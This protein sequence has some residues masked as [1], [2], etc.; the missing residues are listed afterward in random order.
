VPSNDPIQRFEDILENI[1]LIEEFTSGMSPNTFLEDLKTR[2]AT[3]RCM[4]RISEAARK[5]GNWLRNCVQLF[6]GPACAR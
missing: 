5:L 2:N 3:E 4:E 1:I 6:R